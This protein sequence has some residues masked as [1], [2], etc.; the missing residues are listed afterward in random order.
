MTST[1]STIDIA[2]IIGYFLLVLGIGFYI[3]RKTKTGED[4]FLGGRT[5]GWGLIGLSLFASNISSST[6]IGLSG[7]AYSTGIATSV[8]E[9]MSGIPLIIAATIFV[10]L[11]LRSKVTTIP[12]FLEKRF[13]RRSQLFFSAITIFSTIMIE[14]AGGLY[15]GTLVLQAFFPNLVMWQTAMAL[16]FIAGIYTAFGGLKA[17]VYTDAIQAVILILGCGILTWILLGKVDFDLAK[18]MAAA[19]PEHFSVVRP[20]DDESLPWLGLLVGVP[21]LGFWYWSTNQYI[22]QRVLGGRDIRHARWGVI[23]AGFLKIIP[24]FVMVIP[25]AIA[26][27]VYPN[28]ENGDSVF[29]FLVTNVLPVGLVGLVLAGLVSAI[30]SSVDS[31]LNSSS[32]LMVIDFIKPGRP[33]MS[34]E[35]MVKAGRISTIV[36]MVLAALW[37][38][39]IANF[40]GLWDYLQQM[41]SIIVPPIVVIFLVGVFY[42]R[43]N[44]HGAFW[45]LVFGT[46]I[47]V[48]LFI[49]GENGMWPLHFTVNV[50]FMI[51]VSSVIFVV[52]SQMTPAPTKEQTELLTYR[53]GLIMDGMEGYPWYQDYRLWMAILFGLIMYILVV[54]W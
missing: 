33:N 40:T 17:V 15:A 45:T 43:G 20:M 5:F 8:Y 54:L 7:A 18:V 12:E 48:L 31:A 37:A 49:L 21:F 32:T 6:I 53:K 4:L 30:M 27:T 42:K 29:P 35:E 10:P 22:V 11:Y 38:P 2:I 34:N 25:G 28:I 36:F 3:A 46:L 16:A 13:D 50:G 52:V 24:L 44:G 26:L 39:Q 9:W 19:P 14:T 41:F 51:L 23:F 47:G 1:I